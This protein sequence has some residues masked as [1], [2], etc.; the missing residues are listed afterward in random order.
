MY[1]FS[2]FQEDLAT[3]SQRQTFLKIKLKICST[4]TIFMKKTGS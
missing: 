2:F 1:S 4:Q 3:F